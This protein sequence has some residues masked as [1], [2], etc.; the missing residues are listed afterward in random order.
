MD[1]GSEHFAEYAQL[2]VFNILVLLFRDHRVDYNTE[3]QEERVLCEKQNE[4]DTLDLMACKF[5]DEQI[6]NDNSLE[7]KQT[8]G[9]AP[10][11]Y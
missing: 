2:V 4:K 5:I 10:A 1:E 7:Y 8:L 11:R 9:F 3:G 6:E